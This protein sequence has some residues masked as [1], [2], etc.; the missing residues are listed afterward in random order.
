MPPVPKAEQA[1]IKK[2][3]QRKVGSTDA[4]GRIAGVMDF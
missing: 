2:R 1:I 3:I 4:P